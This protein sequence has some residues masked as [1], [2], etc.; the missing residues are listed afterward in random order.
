M[1]AGGVC[2]FIYGITKLINQWDIKKD[3]GRIV[4]HIEQ[5]LAPAQAN[6]ADNA[7]NDNNQVINQV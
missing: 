7:V 1:T 2:T 3:A 4:T 6:Q 5:R